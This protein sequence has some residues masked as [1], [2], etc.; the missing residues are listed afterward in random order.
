VIGDFLKPPTD[1][2]YKFITISGL[3]LQLIFLLFIPWNVHRVIVASTEEESTFE[4]LKIDAI[5]EKR[6]TDEYH[7]ERAL[8][9][10]AQVAKDDKINALQ[11]QVDNNSHL[12]RSDRAAILSEIQQMTAERYQRYR[13][14]RDLYIAANTSYIDALKRQAEL[15][16]KARS[17]RLERKLG[18]IVS[19]VLLF[20]FVVGSAL[21]IKGFSLWFYRVQVFQDAILRQQA[22]IE[23]E[24]TGAA[25]PEPA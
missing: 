1:N 10:N 8:W 12:S 14:A 19:V 5:E 20:S 3:V 16:A 4:I 13:I 9:Q 6:A 24:T 25:E 17:S 15:R 22:K 18:I 2:L 11:D 21:T 23:S 7:T